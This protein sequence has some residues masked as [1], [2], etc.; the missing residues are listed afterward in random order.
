VTRETIVD[1]DR[2]VA[3]LDEEWDALIALGAELEPEDWQRPT[4]CPGW[5]VKD[6]YAHIIGTE[7]ML[8][9]RASP[10]IDLPADLPHV[11]NDIGRFNEVWVEAYRSK[12]P[13]D[14]L[15]DLG[16]VITERRAALAKQSQADFD[17]PSWTPAGEDTYGRFM[18]IRVLDQWFHE[19]DVREAVDRPGHV[20]GT[21][22]EVVLDE[23]AAVLGYVVGKLAAVPP[24]NSVRFEL[25]GPMSRTYDVEVDDR[26]R[27]VDRLRGEPTV[28][29]SLPGTL[30]CRLAGGRRSADDPDVREAVAT[31]GD[32]KLADQVLSNLAFM[33]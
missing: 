10:E 25:T 4:A 13:V 15:S 27:V 12:S 29:L 30:F 9:G 31:R 18:S 17:E 28:T 21:A 23:F 5:S 1:R 24:D 14:V 20:A 2:V 3:A 11:H 8:L 26:A 16:D 33:V 6:Q 22:P 7:S 32:G 19:Q